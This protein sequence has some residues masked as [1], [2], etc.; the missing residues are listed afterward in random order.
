MSI[1]ERS[2]PWDHTY[3]ALVLAA[4]L[5]RWLRSKQ[6]LRMDTEVFMEFPWAG[7]RVDIVTL[8]R[9]LRSAAFELKLRASGRALE[10]ALY[11]RGAFDRSYIVVDQVPGPRLL[12][13]AE[14][15]GVGVIHINEGV[16]RLLV[17]SP[18]QRSSEP[19]R[20]RLLRSLRTREAVDLS[21]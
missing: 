11:N 19:I 18:L 20:T 7:R 12:S 13:Q 9:G 3:E 16:V 6:R 21:P 14:A 15:H 8:S 10:Q 5:L 1:I 4:P 2:P 17:E